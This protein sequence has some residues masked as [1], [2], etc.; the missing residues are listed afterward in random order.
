MKKNIITLVLICGF[1]FMGCGT[2]KSW[3][4]WGED[5]EAGENLTPP[6][7]EEVQKNPDGTYNF[8]EEQLDSQKT[9]WGK[10]VLLS[11][12]LVAT[13]LVVRNAVKNKSK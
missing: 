2:I 12:I 5:K 7:E 6:L 13:G 10:W 8:T 9:S 4:G 11:G 3:V 1:I